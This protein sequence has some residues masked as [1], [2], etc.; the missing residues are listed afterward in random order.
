[1][2]RKVRLMIFAIIVSL[3]ILLY[4][5][6][7]PATTHYMPKCIFK[8]LTGYDCPSCGGQRVFHLLLHGEIKKAFLLNPFLFIVAPYLLAIL[9]TTISKS[10]VATTIKPCLTHHIA[11][12]AHLIV[13]ILWW[14]VRN[15]EWWHTLLEK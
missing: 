14:V 7:N 2:N 8:L 13:C 9:Y 1:M 6:V 4:F 5:C 10:K 11:I 3:L 12:G 15:T